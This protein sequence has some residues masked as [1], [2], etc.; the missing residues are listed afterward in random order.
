[1]IKYK[2][3]GN[4]QGCDRRE[5]FLSKSKI[6]PGNTWV[7]YCESVNCANHRFYTIS[8]SKI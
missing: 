3:P 2:I 6:K 4:C 1:M 5:T 8:C 7:R